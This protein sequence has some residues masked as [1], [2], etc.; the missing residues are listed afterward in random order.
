MDTAGKAIQTRAG[1]EEGGEAIDSVDVE[2][3][4]SLF[5]AE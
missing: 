2:N 5:A 4:P 3:K 1:V